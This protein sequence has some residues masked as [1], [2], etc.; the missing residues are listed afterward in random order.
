M[1]SDKKQQGLADARKM[2]SIF[3]R[4]GKK[5]PQDPEYQFLWGWSF[6]WQAILLRDLKQLDESEVASE[7]AIAIL[8]KA[9]AKHPKHA[10][11][12][13]KL[14]AC[15]LHRAQLFVDRKQRGKAQEYYQLAIGQLVNP[16]S[17]KDARAQDLDFFL[18][19]AGEAAAGMRDW[20]TAIK[21]FTERASLNPDDPDCRYHLAIALLA[22]DELA[23]YREVCAE[24]FEQFHSTDTN[25][26]AARIAYTC[27]P[28]Q[29]AIPELERLTPL[30]KMAVNAWQGNVR[31]RGA[32]AYRSGDHESAANFF[33]ELNESD[34]RAWDW[35]FM[36]MTQSRLGHFDEAR[37]C[38]DQGIRLLENSTDMGWTEKVESQCLREEASAL[39][40]SHQQATKQYSRNDLSRDI[41]N[42]LEITSRCAGG[43]VVRALLPVVWNRR[44]RVPVL[45]G[46]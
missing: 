34:R 31:L 11:C 2:E 22:N 23:R 4:L 27:V 36:S 6:G 35:L 13:V 32:V 20:P 43:N 25:D 29:D 9:A 26:I 39:I 16:I 44:A 21:V 33:D 46:S 28:A 45:R 14:G 41:R 24:T 12:S 1:G 15:Y 5:F 8:E 37:Q 30:A 40:E 7:K 38:L 10:G 17:P 3:A 42:W 19:I 18:R